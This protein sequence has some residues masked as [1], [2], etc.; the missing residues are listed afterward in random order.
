MQCNSVDPPVNVNRGVNA[1]NEG[2]AI[3]EDLVRSFVCAEAIPHAGTT[4][5]HLCG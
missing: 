4:I 3:L 2:A 5:R 1:G